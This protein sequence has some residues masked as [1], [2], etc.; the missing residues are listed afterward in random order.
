M[1]SQRIQGAE[2]KLNPAN[3]GPMEVRVHVQNDQASVFFTAH[4]GAVREALE[5]ALPRLRDMFEASGVE[6]VDVD[7]SDQSFAEQRAMQDE[8]RSGWGAAA[9]QEAPEGAPEILMETPLNQMTGV[10]TLDLFV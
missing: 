4:H 6:L 3:L 10:G 9:G 7:V 5:S 2:V 1:V 8:G